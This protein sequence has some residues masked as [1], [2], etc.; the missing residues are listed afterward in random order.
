MPTHGWLMAGERYAQSLRQ[1]NASASRIV[2]KQLFNYLELGAAGLMLK[3]IRVIHCIRDPMDTLWSCYSNAFRNDRG[4]TNDFD[5]LGN[6]WLLY[7]QLMRHWQKQ[8]P[9]IHEIRYENLVADVA[10][11]ARKLIEFLGLEWDEACLSFHDNPRQ[12]T[13]ASQVQIRQNIY[14]SSVGRWRNYERQLQ[15]LREIIGTT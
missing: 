1:R 15:P 6:A 13:T 14:Q 3:N 12:V 11:E 10:G 7:R 5:D 4:F 2:D 9:G 8:I